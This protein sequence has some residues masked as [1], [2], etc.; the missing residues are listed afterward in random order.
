VSSRPDTADIRLPK[1]NVPAFI[2]NQ[3]DTDA[4]LIYGGT[5]RAFSPFG[6]AL[7]LPKLATPGHGP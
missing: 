2:P 6:A 4:T 5:T 3:Q 7:W 1:A